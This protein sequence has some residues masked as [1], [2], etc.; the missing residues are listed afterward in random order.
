TEFKQ[1]N[2]AWTRADFGDGGYAIIDQNAADTTNVV[3][4]H[5]YFNQTN[6]MGFARVTNVANATD[7]GWPG[8]GRG[9]RRL[10]A[11]GITGRASAILFYAPVARGPGNPNTLY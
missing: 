5:T 2:G 6:A 11:N 9:F 4:Y 8:F 7:N 10:I 3:M 1:P